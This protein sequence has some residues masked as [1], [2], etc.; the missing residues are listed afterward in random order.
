M[1]DKKAREERKRIKGITPVHKIGKDSFANTRTD[2]IRAGVVLGMIGLMA[3]GSALWL[4]DHF[5]DDDLPPAVPGWQPISLTDGIPCEV[6]NMQDDPL[7][8]GYLQEFL[9]EQ[10]YYDGPVDQAYGPTVISAVAAFQ[11]DAQT[12]GEYTAPIDGKPGPITCAA[13]VAAGDE[14]FVVD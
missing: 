5:T 7:Q 14:H 3:V 12:R 2:R 11:A 6:S 13:M 9:Q 1:F 8:T 4:R 10:G